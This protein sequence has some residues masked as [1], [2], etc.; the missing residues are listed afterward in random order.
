MDYASMARPSVALPITAAA[1]WLAYLIALGFYRLYL[2]PIAKFPG[3]KLAALSLWYEF[4]YE[5]VLKGQFSFHIQ[6]LHKRYGNHLL[7]PPSSA[8]QCW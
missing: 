5:V 2:S 8:S 3:P 7:S 4:Y 6:E 1:I